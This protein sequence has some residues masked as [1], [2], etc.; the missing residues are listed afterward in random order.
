[1]VFKDKLNEIFGIG[2]PTIVMPQ[3]KPRDVIELTPIEDFRNNVRAKLNGIKSNAVMGIVSGS[4]PSIDTQSPECC[5]G[6]IS[7]GDEKISLTNVKNMV[8]QLG[9][10][11]IS[12]LVA[13]LSTDKTE[14]DKGSGEAKSKF[15]IFVDGLNQKAIGV[16]LGK[17]ANSSTPST[18]TTPGAPAPIEGATPEA[19]KTPEE[20]AAKSIV[21]DL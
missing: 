6:I 3:E 4:Q 14:V 15:E 2:A 16:V 17:D 21:T 10:Q 19:P 12:E 7:E 1:M 11:K 9:P 5:D 18:P 13:K 8:L 20:K